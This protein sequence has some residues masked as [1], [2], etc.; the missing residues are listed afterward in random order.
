MWH[1]LSHLYLTILL[2]FFQSEF[3]TQY[4]FECAFLLIHNLSGWKNIFTYCSKATCPSTIHPSKCWW[5][6]LHSCS[7]EEVDSIS[8][9]PFGDKTQTTDDPPG[10]S[11]DKMRT[12][13]K[14]PGTRHGPLTTVREQDANNCNNCCVSSGGVWI[15]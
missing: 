6:Q 15:I 13:D 8:T 12:T 9:C 14:S 11:R 7:R 2:I 3:D 4:Y 1:G 5:C 10:S